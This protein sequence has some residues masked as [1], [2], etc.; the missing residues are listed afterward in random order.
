MTGGEEVVAVFGWSQAVPQ[1]CPE[2]WVSPL[3]PLS[4]EFG[5]FIVSGLYDL[6]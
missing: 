6:R 2:L 5:V 4:R 1:V 3:T